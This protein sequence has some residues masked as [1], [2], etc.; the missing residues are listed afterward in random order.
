VRTVAIRLVGWATLLV[1]ALGPPG[2]GPVLA[3]E[4]A[5]G[6]DEVTQ[7]AGVR[8]VHDS[9][10]PLMYPPQ[11]MG[12]GCAFGDYDGDGWVDLYFPGET[13]PPTRVRSP[14]GPRTGRLFRNRRDGS[15]EDVTARTGLACE[16][17]YLGAS[18]ADVDN[19]GSLDLHLTGF[20]ESRLFLN[21]GDGTFRDQTAGSGLAMKGR[22]ATHATWGDYDHDGLLD[23]YV[24][25]YLDFH[26]PAA[27]RQ[28]EVTNW[29]G[30]EVPAP[31]VPPLYDGTPH[32][33]FHN[34]GGGRFTDVTARAGVAD[35]EDRLGKGLG[36]LWSDVD[37]DGWIDLVLA[38][39]GVRKTLFLN[40]KDGT[41][42]SAAR[43]MWMTDHFGSMGV[44][45]A[46]V[47]GD[48]FVDVH[49]TNWFLEPNTLY[50]NRRGT[51]FVES[52]GPAGLAD[53]TAPLVGWGTEFLDYDLDGHMDLAV[54]CGSTFAARYD[55]KTYLTDPGLMEP[56]PTLLFRGDGTGKFA[57]VTR[58]AGLEKLM[59]VGRGLAVAD[60][61]HD[62]APDV[63]IG[64]NN[65]PAV[66]LHNR[67]PRG[68]GWITVLLSSKRSNRRGI[69][70]R[71]VVTAGGTIQTRELH[72][73]S[74]YLSCSAGEASFGLGKAH[75]VDELVVHWPSGTVTT[76]RDVPADRRLVVE[77]R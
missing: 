66:L 19:D 65:G 20:G 2:A 36:A 64:V 72:A 50:L 67:G 47:N 28:P 40:R 53:R 43:K 59:I 56:Q 39:D 57:E 62:G 13:S 52:S 18:W 29:R 14:A 76:L 70:G 6:F 75:K 44:S 23:V 4:V 35:N 12:P 15:F 3:A 25:T 42:R 58:E 69:G 77:E 31:L 22:F 49:F 37:N 63:A 11:I 1:S 30:H 8:F 33:L 41:F 61:D 5:A 26:Y 9:G 68:S 27:D 45:A 7:L 16:G 38:N 24:T 21:R 51:F 71:V 74:S 54:T 34:E 17:E 46:D 48:G 60:Y 10:A 55:W 32:A 73:G